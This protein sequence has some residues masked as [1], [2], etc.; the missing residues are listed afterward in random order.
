MSKLITRWRRAAVVGACALGALA[1]AAV[2]ATPAAAGLPGLE[3]VSDQTGS[4]TDS[5]KSKTVSCPAGKVIISG[6]AYLVG[7]TG[8]HIDMLRPD[9]GGTFFGAAASG[10]PA[11]RE[12][13]RLIVYG[14]CALPPPGL[15]YVPAV[16]SQSYDSP[17]RGAL[18]T[19]PRDTKLI[20]FG[21][22]AAVE[23]GRNVALTAMLP[24][25]DLT[26]VIV[27]SYALEGGE[28]DDWTAEAYAVCADPLPN[29][30][31]IRMTVGPNPDDSKVAWSQC[32]SGTLLHAIGAGIFSA[33][34]Q[35]W[36]GGL[37]P[38]PD[39]HNGT[40][41]AVEDPTG[42]NFPWY[43]TSAGICA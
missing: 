29:A 40:A 37:Y 10:Q 4:N 42:T 24:S 2:T 13:W 1:G 35:A 21:G 41:I 22:R 18:A 34:G 9:P 14:I 15:V 31:V 5:T 38:A 12:A 6:G 27:Q 3:F 25:V 43:V 26:R 7:G 16:Q 30:Q 20:G 17:L 32:P 36:Y 11:R 39:L 28:T 19:C 23:P 33:G 8:V